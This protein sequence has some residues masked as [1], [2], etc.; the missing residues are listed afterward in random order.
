MKQNRMSV[1]RGATIFTEAERGDT[2]YVIVEGRVQIERAG[3]KASVVLATLEPGSF[4]GEMAV[5]DQAER[6]ATA[7]ALTD[8]SL[9]A[10]H[11][12]EL[13][14]LLEQR[15]DVGAKMIRTLVRRLKHTTNQVMDEKEKIALLFDSGADT[16]PT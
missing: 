15:P 4:F 2:M 6:T 8:V 13:E 10:V 16:R 11:A 12:S 14:L 9:L 1:S 3:S 7:V 5:V